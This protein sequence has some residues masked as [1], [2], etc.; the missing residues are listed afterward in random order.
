MRRQRYSDAIGDLL[1]IIIDTSYGNR[2]PAPFYR[3]RLPADSHTKAI[4]LCNRIRSAGGSCVV[5]P[6]P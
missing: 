4:G 5:L 2:G 6:N 1:P 3:V